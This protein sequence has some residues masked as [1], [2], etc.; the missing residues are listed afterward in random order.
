M[1]GTKSN[2]RGICE[3]FGASGR[4]SKARQASAKLYMFGESDYV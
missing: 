2:Q 1:I 3:G 4:R